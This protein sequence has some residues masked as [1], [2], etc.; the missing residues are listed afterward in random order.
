[1]PRW[2]HQK[3][4]KYP[5]LVG[6]VCFASHQFCS[7]RWQYPARVG[8]TQGRVGLGKADTA[9]SDEVPS[10]RGMDSGRAPLSSC[11]FRLAVP[12]CSLPALT[13]TLAPRKGFSVSH[14]HISMNFSIPRGLWFHHEIKLFILFPW[15]PT[16]CVCVGGGGSLALNEKM[17]RSSNSVLA[18]PGLSHPHPQDQNLLYSLSSAAHVFTF[19][20]H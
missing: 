19:I 1:M 5:Q 11:T 4:L 12:S 13:Y 3:P 14:L 10:R 15:N 17:G 16:M 6:G 2:Y 8:A 18:I 20:S 7:E 9:G